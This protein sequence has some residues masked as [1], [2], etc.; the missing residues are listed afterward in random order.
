M[1]PFLVL[2]P[3]SALTESV[4]VDLA[5]ATL[6]AVCRQL[7]LLPV[8][9][10]RLVKRSPLPAAETEEASQRPLSTATTTLRKLSFWPFRSLLS[11]SSLRNCLSSLQCLREIIVS[12]LL[13]TTLTE[14][15]A[16]WCGLCIGHLDLGV[17][18]RV[19]DSSPEAAMTLVA[20]TMPM[21]GSTPAQRLQGKGEEKEQ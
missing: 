9:P 2:L 12:L 6:C 8:K 19:L 7:V 13:P 16:V 21:P 11:L 14:V 1:G 20:M 17:V 3:L 5:V 18:L 15:D 10:L 4:V